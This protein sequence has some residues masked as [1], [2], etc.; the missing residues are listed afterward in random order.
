MAGLRPD[1]VVIVATVRALKYHGG[2]PKAEL[3]KENLEC[4]EKGLPNLLKHVENITKVFGLPAVVAINRFP[5]D[6]EDELKLV[7]TKCR[8]LG[9]N[10]ALSEVWAKGGLGGIEL[11]KEVVRLT[12]E[13][14]SNFTFSYGLDLTI[15]EKIE[16]I[17]KRIYGGSRAVGET[18]FWQSPYLYSKDTVF[19]F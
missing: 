17:V 9:V 14:G 5:T 11:A 19:T 16:T 10:V 6:T 3:G 4:L 2:V 7:Y 1:A 15:R 13:G 12:E 18:G 8:E